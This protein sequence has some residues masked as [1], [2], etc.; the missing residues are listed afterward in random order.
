MKNILENWAIKDIQ[1]I[2]KKNKKS[3]IRILSKKWKE[4]QNPENMRKDEEYEQWWFFIF[5]TNTD[6]RNSTC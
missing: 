5:G 2:Y 4:I 1:G 3:L 6:W